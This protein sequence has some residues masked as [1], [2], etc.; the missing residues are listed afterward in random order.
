MKKLSQSAY[1]FFSY[2]STGLLLRYKRKTYLFFD[3]ILTAGPLGPGGPSMS[4][5]FEN[6]KN[7]TH[8]QNE[9]QLEVK[10]Q[11]AISAL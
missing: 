6:R 8:S 7:N 10:L 9:L 1:C 5:P 11:C 4:I 2:K 3:N